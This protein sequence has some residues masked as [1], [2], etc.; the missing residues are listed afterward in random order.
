MPAP[1]PANR[2]FVLVN[3]A[4][5][6]DGKI[7]TANRKVSTF[8]S[9]RDHDHL[10]ELRAT[11]DAVM[12]GAATLNAGQ[13]DLGP[14]GARY[15]RLRLKNNLPEY[16][17]RILVSGA[18]SIDPKAHIFTKRFSPIHILATDRL[19]GSR[20]KQLQNA[21]DS[22]TSW[23]KNEIDF[24]KA[25]AWLRREHGVKRLLC[26]GG[27]TLNDALFRAGLVDE[28]HLTLCPLIFAGADAPTI[29][30]GQGFT[31][32]AAAARF[33]LKSR[34]T[35]GNEQFLLFERSNAPTTRA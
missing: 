18:G 16:N 31:P 29:S 15:R 17:L 4:L 30:D 26:E 33:Q 8:G 25:L 20:L 5:T 14:G 9:R 23:G 6:A 12:S 28:I 10:L 32:L 13:V 11:V 2:P 34:R 7:A 22:V 1:H 24:A 35:L 27:G 19:R 3:M 21:A